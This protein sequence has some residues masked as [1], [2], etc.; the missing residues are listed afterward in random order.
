[1]I[2]DLIECRE[3]ALEEETVKTQD[4][5]RQGNMEALAIRRQK[6]E[7]NHRTKASKELSVFS[8]L[9]HITYIKTHAL[10]MLVFISDDD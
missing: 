2:S 6:P 4:K 5:R 8:L 3:R 9:Y 10:V 1:M 7:L